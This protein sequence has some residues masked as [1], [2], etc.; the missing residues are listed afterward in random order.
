MDSVYGYITD[1][2]LRLVSSIIGSV[3]VFLLIVV[4]IRFSHDRESSHMGEVLYIAVIW[5]IYMAVFA[6]VVPPE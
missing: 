1:F 2:A 6:T 5:G 3:I 4:I